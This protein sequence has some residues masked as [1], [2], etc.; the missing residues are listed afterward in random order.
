FAC[1]SQYNMTRFLAAL[2]L[3][4]TSQLLVSQ[5]SPNPLTTSGAPQARQIER[6]QQPA[7]RPVAL[8]AVSASHQ[9]PNGVEIAS[10]NG[11]LRITMLQNDVIRVR[12]TRG[13]EF[14][15]KSSY[16]VLPVPSG[17]QPA[18]AKPQVR[19]APDRIE[20]STESLQVRV[21]RPDSTISFL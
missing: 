18:I 19:E 10:E 7:A 21:D 17:A 6:P 5:T 4:L 8:G 15:Q 13:S 12:A 16:A 2:L 3:A 14:P 11:R 9:L 20:L 1:L